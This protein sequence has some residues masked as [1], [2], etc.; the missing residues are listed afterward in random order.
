MKRKK[1]SVRKPVR[2][3]RRGAGS[4]GGGRS[5]GGRSGG[6]RSGGRVKRKKKAK[7]KSKNPWIAFVNSYKRQNPQWKQEFGSYS[8]LLQVLAPEY[9]SGKGMSGGMLMDNVGDYYGGMLMDNV[10]DYYGG[11]LMDNVGDYY[12]GMLMDNVGDYEGGALVGTNPCG[13][14]G[15]L[16]GSGCGICNLCSGGYCVGQEGQ[17]RG[18]AL[19]DGSHDYY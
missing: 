11:M 2:K 14:C 8:Q 15:K 18:G 19:V 10:G 5:G 1:K 17:W 13:L 12:G 3:L 7:K 6:G 16:T 9:R 4:S